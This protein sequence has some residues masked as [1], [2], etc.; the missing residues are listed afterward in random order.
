M[1]EGTDEEGKPSI[2]DES[3]LYFSSNWSTGEGGCIG[4][5]DMFK[6]TED[7]SPTT[8]LPENKETHHQ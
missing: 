3:C 8:I 1:L 7:Q 5:S 6:Q 4:H 2:L